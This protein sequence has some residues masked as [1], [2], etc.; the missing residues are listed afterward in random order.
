MS[1]STQDIVR[2]R[3]RLFTLR[4]GK[5]NTKYHGARFVNG[6]AEPV[7]YRTARRLKAA[8][9]SSL[10]VTFYEPPRPKRKP[11]PRRAAPPPEPAPVITPE[12]EPQPE[13]VA[14]AIE[15]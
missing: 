5:K 4:R 8:F 10:T 1:L 7:K 14:P 3:D 12:P 15:D 11:R 6:V 13:P 9:G 2:N